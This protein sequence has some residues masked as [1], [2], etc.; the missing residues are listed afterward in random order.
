M[1]GHGKEGELS[2]I[3]N[4]MSSSADISA[5]A[6][7]VY[8][9]LDVTNWDKSGFFLYSIVTQN[10]QPQDLEQIYSLAKQL[11][12]QMIKQTEIEIDL[13]G[14]SGN[15]AA[16]AIYLKP[17]LDN[18]GNTYTF[19]GVSNG[20]FDQT[21]AMDDGEDLSLNQN[22]K[23]SLE[24]VYR[25]GNDST[26]RTVVFVCPVC[27]GKGVPFTLYVADSEH[28]KP[29]VIDPHIKNGGYGFQRHQRKPPRFA[30]K[31]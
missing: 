5:V 11:S 1:A 22:G 28:P 15:M 9:T 3:H 19:A 6:G 8:V 25:Y 16:V 26:G 17:V 10:G 4:A 18:Q 29:L 23:A 21:Q 14:V 27:A 30:A 2:N 24:F 31:R 7:V 12:G 20:S 13:G